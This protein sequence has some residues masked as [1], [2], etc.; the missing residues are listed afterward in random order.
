MTD[1]YRPSRPD[2]D[3]DR[4]RPPPLADRMTF[5]TGAGDSYRPAQSDFTFE[6]NHAAPRFPPSGPAND[7]SR[8][9]QGGSR[10]GGA[11]RGRGRGRGG[12]HHGRNNANGARRGGP[13]KKQ[14]PHERALLRHRDN[15]S[16]EHTY[17]VDGPSRF[18]NLDDM[19]DD[20][21]AAMDESDVS[22]G[23]N[24]GPADSKVA[25][26][27]APRADGNSVPKWSNPDPY[28]ALPPP[29]ETT[30]VKKDVVQLIRK[31]KN[32]E[33]EKAIGNNAVAANDDFISFADDDDDDDVDEEIDD[34]PGLRIYEDDEP[35]RGRDKGKGSAR[36]PIEGSMNDLAYIDDMLS[37]PPPRDS[38]Q[39]QTGGGRK[40]RFGGAVDVVPEWLASGRGSHRTPW[41]ESAEKYGHLKDKPERW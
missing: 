23:G 19:S 17:G 38:Y 39:P 31:A 32:Q 14:A 41:A 37:V 2:R 24:D 6:S 36:R 25:R 22:A 26:T 4:D 40:R 8:A 30:G 34:A 7:G 33:A 35:I 16:P 27:Q 3:R 29:S 9:T 10:S 15:G 13:Y 21:E 20:E 5:S 12:D 11:R 18:M 1:T 28:T